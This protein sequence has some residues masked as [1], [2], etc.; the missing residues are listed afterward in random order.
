M[1]E[2]LASIKDKSFT[3][4][5]DALKTH[6][7]EIE[8]KLRESEELL[9]AQIQ[10]TADM[11]AALKI[12]QDERAQERDDLE[13]SVADAEANLQSA[14]IEVEEAHAEVSDL[15]KRM[16]LAPF[17]DATEGG[18]SAVEVAPAGEEGEG[19]EETA[20]AER[21]DDEHAAHMH[22]IEDTTERIAY[23]REHRKAIDKAYKAARSA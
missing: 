4:Q 2:F 3:D 5:M 1:S 20:E 21:T 8:G 11:S 17:E 14:E 15:K 19:D 16:A 12:E 23:Y 9:A 7:V 13:K 18:D 10:E 22:G 6:V